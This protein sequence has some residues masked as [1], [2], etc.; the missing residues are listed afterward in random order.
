M[1]VVRRRHAGEQKRG[2]AD[3]AAT[4]SAVAAPVALRAPRRQ[5]LT[6]SGAVAAVT[7]VRSRG[8]ALWLQS[9]L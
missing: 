2:W 4:Q 1:V 7:A 8:V 5:S 6:D 9:P 3:D